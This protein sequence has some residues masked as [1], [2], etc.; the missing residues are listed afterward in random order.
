[1][2]YGF[3]ANPYCGINI[4]VDSVKDKVSNFNIGKKSVVVI[5]G[6][7]LVFSTLAIGAVGANS[8]ISIDYS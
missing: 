7:T 6:G 2:S 3:N 1:M 8:I 5:V 4:V